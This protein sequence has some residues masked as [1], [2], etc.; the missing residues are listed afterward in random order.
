MPGGSGTRTGT[1]QELMIE[2]L[3]EF[4]HYDYKKQVFIGKQLFNNRYK[5]DFVVDNSIIVSLK[6][7]QVAG[8][9]EQKV[10]YEIASLIKIIENDN[11]KKAYVVIGG[12]GFS[13]NAKEYLFSQ[14]HRNI[15]KHGDLVEN[16]G[17]EDFIARLNNH[18]L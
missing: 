11:F 1:G 3:L 5:A 4:N 16:I 13:Q 2:S 6:W 15:L 17:V 18:N 7:Q 12:N 8:T 9:A 10:I 14:E